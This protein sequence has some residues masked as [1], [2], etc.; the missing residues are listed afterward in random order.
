MWRK[1]CVYM[2]SGCLPGLHRA[3]LLWLEDHN[4]VFTAAVSVSRSLS[5]EPNLRSQGRRLMR[6]LGQEFHFLLKKFHSH[7]DLNPLLVNIPYWNLIKCHP[8]HW[9]RIWSLQETLIWQISFKPRK[10]LFNLPYTNFSSFIMLKYVLYSPNMAFWLA[11]IVTYC[12]YIHCS[13]K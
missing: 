7:Y 6:S 3:T 2:L 11:T 1:H 12:S 13:K 10:Q 5:V 9:T 8:K 4:S